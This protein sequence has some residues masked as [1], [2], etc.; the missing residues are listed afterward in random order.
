[1]PSL[2]VSIQVTSCF[3]V[4]IYVYREREAPTSCHF[5]QYINAIV[6]CSSLYK[7]QFYETSPTVRKFSFRGDE[8]LLYIQTF[9]ASFSQENILNLQHSWLLVSIILSYNQFD[10]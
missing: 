5:P 4:V 1:M 2:I 3:F 7:K 10:I 9:A 6:K 8:L